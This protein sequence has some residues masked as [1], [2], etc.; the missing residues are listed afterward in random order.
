MNVTVSTPPDSHVDLVLEAIGAGAHVLCEKP[1]ALD[2]LD[3]ARMHAAAVAAGVVHFTAF[4]FRWSPLDATVRAA[5]LVYA[6]AIAAASAASGTSLSSAHAAW[7]TSERA[8][9][10]M[11]SMSAHRCDTAW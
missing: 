7:Y 11:T 5:S 9:S 1:F 2:A 3:G 6:F 10:A 4:E 8:D